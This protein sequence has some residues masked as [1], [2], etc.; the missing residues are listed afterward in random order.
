[1]DNLH[2]QLV[3]ITLVPRRQNIAKY[4]RSVFHEDVESFAALIHRRL[5]TILSAEWRH[6]TDDQNQRYKQYSSSVHSVRSVH[7]SLKLAVSVL[8]KTLTNLDVISG[9][10]RK[11]MQN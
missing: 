11:I 1:V 10:A 5:S 7:K 9:A 2:A 4:Q 8:C 3:N 6:N